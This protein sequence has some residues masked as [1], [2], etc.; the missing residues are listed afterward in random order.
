VKKIVVYFIV[1]SLIGYLCFQISDIVLTKLVSF[2]TVATVFSTFYEAFSRKLVVR[3]GI[4][5]NIAILLSL[6]VKIAVISG[7]IYSII[8]SILIILYPGLFTGYQTA[9][10][11][12][13]LI[14]MIFLLLVSIYAISNLS[15]RMKFI[16]SCEHGLWHI[17][18]IVDEDKGAYYEK[19]KTILSS[20][21][22]L[23]SKKYTFGRS[24]SVWILIPDFDEDGKHFKVVHCKCSDEDKFAYSE[25]NG[26]K[27]PFLDIKRWIAECDKLHEKSKD[28]TDE[29]LVKEYKK[30]KSHT[31]NFSSACGYVYLRKLT[32]PEVA[33]SVEHQCVFYN[34]E[35][36]NLFKNKKDDLKRVSWR[37]MMT[38]YIA[39]ERKKIGVIFFFDTLNNGFSQRDRK[40]MKILANMIAPLIFYGINRGFYGEKSV[41]ML[42][43]SKLIDSEDEVEKAL[44]PRYKTKEWKKKIRILQDLAKKSRAIAQG[45]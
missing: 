22:T 42:E 29:A 30:F 35:F 27:V 13:S 28:L 44:G 4:K 21:L 41:K 15:F 33:R 31:N 11:S 38:W 23:I 36:K 39:Y 20:T 3:G 2:I 8:L 1:F 16:D 6:L 5:E 17:N 26:Y 9:F 24:R 10:H 19:V 14:L 45:Y 7:L 40:T 37:S 32:D 25:M 12:I 34:D 43:K 18:N